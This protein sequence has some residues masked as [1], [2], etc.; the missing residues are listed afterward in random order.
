MQRNHRFAARAAVAAVASS[1]AWIVAASGAHG[2]ASQVHETATLRAQLPGA[3][4]ALGNAVALDGDVL[5]VGAPIDGT[6]TAPGSVLIFERSAPGQWQEVMRFFADVPTNFDLLGGAVDVDGDTAVAG[7]VFD[8]TSGG[9]G[10]VYVY[11]RDVGGLWSQTQRLLSS[12]GRVFDEFGADVALDGDVL[13]VG[14]PRHE[15]SANPNEDSGAVY[16]FERAAGTWTEVAKV[17]PAMLGISAR[18]G[19]GLDLEAG[20]LVA[21]TRAAGGAYVFTGAG[22]TWTEQVRLDSPI[23]SS[24]VDFLR[25]LSLSGDT[26]LV[27]AITDAS[28]GLNTGAVNVWRGAGDTWILEDRL[29][30]PTPAAGDQF[31]VSIALQGDVAIVGS[32]GDDEGGSS[33]GSA[34]LWTRTGT[35]WHGRRELLSGARAASDLLGRAVAVDA[36]TFAAGAPGADGV[37]GGPANVGAVLLLE[38]GA[39]T[40][41]PFCFGDGGDQ[42]GCTNCPCGNEAPRAGLL[43]GGCRNGAAGSAELVAS[44]EASV[45]ADSLRFVLHDANPSSFAVLVSGDFALPADPLSPCFGIDSGV[46]GGLLDGLR[47]VGGNVLRHG[48]RA[49]DPNGDVGL[50]TPGWGPPDGPAGGLLASSGFVSG[51]VR[52]FQVF[53][54]EAAG[55][56]CATGQNTS[57]GVAV[58]FVP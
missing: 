17:V 48:P 39:R 49:S 30:S 5:V 29:H 25:D 24:Q 10:S 33:A 45:A 14:A 40:G 57:Q 51:Q 41:T 34:S 36:T 47:C 3:G 56:V 58:T 31:G 4:E 42:M 27:G 12:D 15:L 13:A 50:S 53:Y 43:R 55:A 2:Q 44:G 37:G 23:V 38:L 20:T 46:A 19:L 22:A 32:W 8:G 9:R 28:S 7:C 6:V 26:L 18:F 1:F 11:V 52:R 21:T 35:A 54:R 16:V